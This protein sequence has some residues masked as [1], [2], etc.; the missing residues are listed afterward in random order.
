[1]K[2]KG[3]YFNMADAWYLNNNN[4]IHVFHL[5]SHSGENWNVGHLYTDDLLHFN[6]M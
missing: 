3:T 6:K 1:M 2:Y 5:K 4:T